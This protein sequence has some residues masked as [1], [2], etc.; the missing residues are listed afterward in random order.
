MVVREEDS[1]NF[2]CFAIGFPPPDITWVDANN[3]TLSIETE[4]RITIDTP[5]PYR[6]ISGYFYSTSRLEISSSRRTD[7]GDEYSCVASNIIQSEPVNQRRV[8]TLTVTCK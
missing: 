6:H 2:T 5:E 4:D 1:V 3:N 8:F 7:L